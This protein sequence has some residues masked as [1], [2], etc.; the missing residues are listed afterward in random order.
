LRTPSVDR[1]TI[2]IN[3]LLEP[4]GRITGIT[5]YLFALLSELLRRQRFHYVL[6]TAWRRDQLPAAL[7]A[8]GLEVTTR[9]FRR[10][11]PHNVAVQMLTVRRLMHETRAVAEFN[12][13]PVGCFRPGWPRVIT[14]HD[15]Y[16]DVIPE[17][18]RRR[19]LLWWKLLFP[20]ALAGASRV[21]CVSEATRADLS[22]HYPH[23]VGKAEV[24]HE[25]SALKLPAEPIEALRR[26]TP[27]AI[28]VGNVSPN[29]NPRGLAK[30]LAILEK[31]SRPL[32]VLHVGRDDAG[33]L[34]RAVAEAGLRQRVQSLGSLS[35]AAL[36]AAYRGAA[37]MIV[38]S[39]HEGFC[40]PLLEAQSC[41]TPVICSDIPVLC[42]V[43]GDAALFF[44]PHKAE[45]L[46]NTIE[47]MHDDDALRQHL[48]QAG[49]KNAERFSWVRAAEE[50]EAILKAVAGQPR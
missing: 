36:I 48:S 3:H 9:P 25:A 7:A 4:P 18:Y 27:Y 6:A 8:S 46:A 35:D 43:A 13:N 15:L 23:F 41:G 1:P 11:L 40:L 49:L 42:E 50:T 32:A 34:A 12:C 22:L 17:S 28:L 2:L 45:T 47:R 10:S 30:A 44:D 19:H 37:F 29:K 21:I 14:V 24:V 33:L 38:P 26:E 16:F 31:R 39:T 5:R 20:R